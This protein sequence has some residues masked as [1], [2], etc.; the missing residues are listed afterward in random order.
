MKRLEEL[1]RKQGPDIDVI[2]NEFE[3]EFHVDEEKAMEINGV[4]D[5]KIYNV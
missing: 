5:K 2:K 4:I 1:R 3:V